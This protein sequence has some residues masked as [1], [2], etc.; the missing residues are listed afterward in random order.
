MAERKRWN[1]TERD[2]GRERYGQKEIDGER[3]REIEGEED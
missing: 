3:Q 2:I 1:E